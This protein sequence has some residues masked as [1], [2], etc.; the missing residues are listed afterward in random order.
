M[1]K[2]Q[3]LEYLTRIAKEYRL[4]C[5]DSV[6]RNCHMNESLGKCGVDQKILDAILVDFI[7]YIGIDQH[8]DYGLYTRDLT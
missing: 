7:N 4:D 5:A 2:I 1:T 8:V 3:L 6:S